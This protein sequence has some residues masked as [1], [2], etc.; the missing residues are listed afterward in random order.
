MRI[1]LAVIALST[2]F[3]FLKLFVENFSIRL[4]KIEGAGKGAAIYRKRP[5]RDRLKK[6]Q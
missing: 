2:I 5:S 6:D 4:V 1:N 3:T